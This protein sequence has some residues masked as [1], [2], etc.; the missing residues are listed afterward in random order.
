[1]NE[2]TRKN[3]SS[4]TFSTLLIR[5]MNLIRIFPPHMRFRFAISL[6]FAAMGAGFIFPLLLIASSLA[7]K[8]IPSSDFFSTPLNFE[9]CIE[10]VPLSNGKIK[11]RISGLKQINEL[12][13]SGTITRLMAVDLDRDGDLDL[14]VNTRSSGLEIWYNDGCGHFSRNPFPQIRSGTVSGAL[15]E[16]TECSSSLCQGPDAHYITLPL[17]IEIFSITRPLHFSTGFFFQ[18]FSRP[19]PLS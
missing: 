19:P 10:L 15:F 1:M 3:E 7:S 13:P 2:I 18:G 12:F 6:V 9:G 8:E 4:R 16:S 5:S 11:A 17:L 14:L